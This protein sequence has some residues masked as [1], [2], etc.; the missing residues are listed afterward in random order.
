MHHRTNLI[1][2]TIPFASADYG[3]FVSAVRQLRRIMGCNA[4]DVLTLIQFNLHDRDA[5][6]IADDFLDAMRWPNSAG[7]V[8]LLKQLRKPRG[9][10]RPGAR[11]RTLAAAA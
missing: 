1:R 8:V 7:R 6:G 10:V 2:I 9:S 4:P 11:V 3:V 5:T